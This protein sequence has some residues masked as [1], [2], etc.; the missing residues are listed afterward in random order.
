MRNR[1]QSRGCK[2]LLSL[3]IIA[4]TACVMKPADSDLPAAWSTWAPTLPVNCQQV[5]FTVAEHAQDTQ[6]QVWL[7][8]R[9][10]TGWEKAP[11]GPFRA[12]IGRHGMAWGAGIH[13]ASAPAGWRLKREGDGCTPAGVFTLGPA[14]GSESRP[15]SLK[16]PYL[17]CTEQHWGV[18]DPQSAHYNQIVDTRQTPV[19]WQG[20]ESMIPRS[21]CYR[22]G[23]VLGHNPQRVPGLGSLI[24]LHIRLGEKVPTSGCTALSAP[25]LQ[26]LLS[27]LDPAQCPHAVQTVRE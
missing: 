21:G 17:L 7:L 2:G 18:D 20:A 1:H 9:T 27:W 5:M 26:K 4:V 13:Q 19:D 11:L 3:L 8:Q 16:M 23:A 24:F 15:P 6:A 10:A 12:C 25:D 14:F 22:L